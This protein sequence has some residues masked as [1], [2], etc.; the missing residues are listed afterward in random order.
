MVS[1]Y[2]PSLTNHPAFPMTAA[3]SAARTQ[4]TVCLNKPLQRM[5]SPV[6]AFLFIRLNAGEDAST[7]PSN[8]RK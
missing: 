1:M 6:N 4:R 3:T 5:I 8:S 7:D 2:L